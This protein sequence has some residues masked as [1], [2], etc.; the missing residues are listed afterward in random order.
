MN[1]FR[2]N[3]AEPALRRGA[4]NDGRDLRGLRFG[5]RVVP[6]SLRSAPAPVAAQQPPRQRLAK[7]PC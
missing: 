4:Q 5:S 3:A 6:E 7:V 2:L 1:V